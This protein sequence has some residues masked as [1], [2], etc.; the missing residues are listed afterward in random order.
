[1]LR[2]PRLSQVDAAE[3][4]DEA[5]TCSV[6][7]SKV[8]LAGLEVR[9]QARSSVSFIEDSDV[10]SSIGQDSDSITSFVPR[11]S[12]VARGEIITGET[13]TYNPEA[14]EAFEAVSVLDHDILGLTREE[15]LLAPEE[16]SF[17]NAPEFV[18]HT[19]LMPA[20]TPMPVASVR[21]PYRSQ[22]ISVPPPPES[23]VESPWVM[24]SARAES[25]VP[26]APRDA[27]SLFQTIAIVGTGVLMLA[28]VFGAVLFARADNQERMEF[29]TPRV[30]AAALAT[31]ASTARV[32]A[33]PTR[34][35]VA[36]PVRTPVVVTP[37]R[38]KDLPPKARVDAPKPIVK[39]EA[40][41]KKT[42]EEEDVEALLKKLGEEQLSR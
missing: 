3:F 2:P 36:T 1:M 16:R 30:A 18:D 25:F 9:P 24:P 41:P 8:A 37:P 10:I 4:D 15:P 19:M 34:A 20:S 5:A 40:A 33:G 7:D 12:Y 17:E 42:K 11:P 13:P 38:V 23:W 28:I 39:A 26:P 14:Y 32:I 22:M 27:R 29:S 31:P 35:P 6:R 21:P